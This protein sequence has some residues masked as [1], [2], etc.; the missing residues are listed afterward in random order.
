MAKT[1]A[2][3]TSQNSGGHSEPV[4]KPIKGTRHIIPYEAISVCKTLGTGEFGTVQQ[5]VWTS[6]AGDRVSRAEGR[7]LVCTFWFVVVGDPF[8]KLL[9]ELLYDF[10]V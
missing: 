9:R 2:D 1:A 8:F 7:H 4:S 10:L 5:G 3:N 6:D